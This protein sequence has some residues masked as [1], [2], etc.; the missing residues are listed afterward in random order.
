MELVQE[1][2]FLTQMGPG[3]PVAP[4]REA[5]GPW[6]RAPRMWGVVNDPGAYMSRRGMH[7][8]GLVVV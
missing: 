5:P 3:V 7:G 6:L 4:L 8:N 1:R 2:S